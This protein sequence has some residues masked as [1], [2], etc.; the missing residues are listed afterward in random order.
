MMIRLLFPFMLKGKV[1]S[2]TRRVKS[3]Y[4]HFVAWEH[5][6]ILDVFFSLIDCLDWTPC[7]NIR[8]Q[9]QIMVPSMLSTL[10][11]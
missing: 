1:Y 6:L 8:L 9:G 4:N 2:V 11:E 5:V 3:M 7:C 10:Y